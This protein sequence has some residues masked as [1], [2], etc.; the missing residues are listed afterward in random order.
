MEFFKI[1]FSFFRKKVVK[2]SIKNGFFL[3]KPSA[4]CNNESEEWEVKSMYTALNIASSVIE[5]YQQQGKGISNLKLQKVL[6]YIQMECLQQCGE[7]AFVDEIEAWRHGPVVRSVYS[8]YKRYIANEI[9]PDDSVVQDNKRCLSAEIE[10]V[11][12]DIVVRTLAIDP[13]G[14]VDM[15]HETIPWIDNYR[16]SYNNVIPKEDLQKGIVNL[17][18]GK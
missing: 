1:V 2:S 17:P 7:L 12:D 10:K 14:L 13:W 18:D 4:I 11:V 9:R 15:T 5:K 3:E 16:S 6:Y 8:R